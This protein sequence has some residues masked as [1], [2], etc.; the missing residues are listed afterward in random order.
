MKLLEIKAKSWGKSNSYEGYAFCDREGKHIPVDIKTHGHGKYSQGYN[1]INTEDYPEG[2]YK[3]IT[4]SGDIK[5]DYYSP[6]GGIKKFQDYRLAPEEVV[7]FAVAFDKEADCYHCKCLQE[8]LRNADVKKNEAAWWK[9]WERE[10]KMDKGSEI[11]EMF[12]EKGIE[13]LDL[14]IERET[15]SLEMEL[16]EVIPR[17]KHGE[18]LKFSRNYQDLHFKKGIAQELDSDKEFKTENERL[19]KEKSEMIELISEEKESTFQDYYR[20]VAEVS[21]SEGVELTEKVLNLLK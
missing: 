1:I 18:F 20:K 11:V 6:E 5:I 2:V 14:K 9:K 21:F 13:S 19:E 12:F 3:V 15:K 8:H 16:L 17:R 10:D 7:E 4:D